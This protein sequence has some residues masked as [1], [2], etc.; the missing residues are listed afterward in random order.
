MTVTFALS[1]RMGDAAGR[2]LRAHGSRRHLFGSG[3]DD[4]TRR[5]AL[6]LLIGLERLPLAAGGRRAVER[7]VIMSS[8]SPLSR[9]VEAGRIAISCIKSENAVRLRS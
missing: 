1:A 3:A 7:G 8:R 2:H 4:D 6:A 5:R 9:E